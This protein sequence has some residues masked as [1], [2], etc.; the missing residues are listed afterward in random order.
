MERNFLFNLSCC[1]G[2]I[3]QWIG[4]KAKRLRE[5]ERESQ[6]WQSCLYGWEMTYSA[7]IKFIL[8]VNRS[9]G[10]IFLFI[11]KTFSIILPCFLYKEMQLLGCNWKN[12]NIIQQGCI[13]L[14][15]HV[16]QKVRKIFSYKCSFYLY[17]PMNI[18][19][20]LVNSAV[21]NIDN[22]KRFLNTI[23]I[24]EWFMEDHVTGVML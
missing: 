11:W 1:C 8:L 17:L 9:L 23:S 15:K 10:F 5:R 13:K 14:I 22:N 20:I 18:S 4:E 21:F 7:E 24:L 3:S 16:K 19:K 2:R 12:N 6:S